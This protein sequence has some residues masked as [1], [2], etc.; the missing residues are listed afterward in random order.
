MYNVYIVSPGDTIDSIAEKFNTTPMDLY[1][2]NT[3]LDPD[4]PL[5]IGQKIIVPVPRT[6]NFE[7]YTV[8][9]GDTL[10]QIAS[11]YNTTVENLALLNGLDDND[12]LYPD[13]KIVVPMKGVEIVV[14]KNGDTLSSV[15]KQLSDNLEQILLQNPTI[16]LLPEQLIVYKRTST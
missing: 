9:K 4:S 15:A 16:Y 2:I 14:T 6:Q 3:F 12:Y 1:Q 10:F 13:Q 8:Q 11:K 7:Y 5:E